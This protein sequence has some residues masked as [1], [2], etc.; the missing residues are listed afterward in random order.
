MPVRGGVG[1]YADGLRYPDGE[2]LTPTARGKREQVRL[3]A[4][5]CSAAGMSPPP[6]VRKL[7][8]SRKSVY[9]WHKAWRT[10]GPEAF[11][12]RGPGG[13][14]CR[15]NQVQAQRLGAALDAGP[16]A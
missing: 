5:G 7:R 16:A 4:A 3:Q 6:V 1:Q 8:A 13:L 15:L 14:R 9:V 10:A 2:G 11:E 12:S